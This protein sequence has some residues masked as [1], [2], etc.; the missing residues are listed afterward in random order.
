MEDVNKKS[1]AE[2]AQFL[3][4]VVGRT[5][6]LAE[7]LDKALPGQDAGAGMKKCADSFKDHLEV[8]TKRAD[9]NAMSDTAKF[10]GIPAEIDMNAVTQLALKDCA[11]TFNFLAE[12]RAA[13][14]VSIDGDR[15][16]ALDLGMHARELFATLATMVHPKKPKIP[17]TDVI[18]GEECFK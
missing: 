8:L 13:D 10:L 9:E 1:N 3:A 15:N 7:L 17:S 4:E 5:V 12:L 2:L 11:D 14:N 18:I 16:Y 6:N